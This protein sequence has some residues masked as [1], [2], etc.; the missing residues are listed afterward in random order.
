[1][2]QIFVSRKWA[3]ALG[4]LFVLPTAYF[5][6]SSI[7]KFE[8]GVPDLYDLAEPFLLNGGINE[9][10]GWNINLLIISGPFITLAISLFSILK[11]KQQNHKELFS[12]DVSIKKNPANVALMITSLLLI[13]FLLMYTI[14]ENCNC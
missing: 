2:K 14:G 10:P 12:F 11:I 6:L 8:L 5:I 7:L 13:T 9:R 3:L 1:M 4:T